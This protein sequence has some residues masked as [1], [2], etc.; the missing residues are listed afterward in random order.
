MVRHGADP[1]TQFNR[2]FCSLLPWPWFPSAGVWSNTGI[3]GC[4]SKLNHQDMDRR[5]WSML[6]L[7]RATHFGYLFL[8]HSH[9]G[10]D[11]ADQTAKSETGPCNKCQQALRPQPFAL[12]TCNRPGAVARRMLRSP[13]LVCHAMLLGT[14]PFERCRS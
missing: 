1:A 14:S 12:N 11:V 13:H 5:F 6:P 9:L 4:G 3:P 8:T 7:T 10:A 2:G